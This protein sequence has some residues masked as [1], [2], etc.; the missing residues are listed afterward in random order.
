MKSNKI[1]EDRKLLSRR[2]V[3][4][5]LGVIA[6]LS[7]VAGLGPTARIA[8]AMQS[9]AIKPDENSVLLVIDFQNCFLPG[10]SL[11]VKGGSEITPVINALG[12]KFKN[13]VFTQDW[14]TPNHTSFA[15]SHPG[16]KPFETVKL[17]YG[18]QVLWPDHCVQGTKGA[19]LSPD[20]DIP[21]A[22]MIVRKGNHSEVDSYSAFLGADQ[23]TTTGL[24]GYLSERGLTKV[25]ICGLAIDFCIRWSAVHAR[26]IGLET[27][28]I[29]DAS[30]TIELN[31]SLESAWS[32][33]KASGVR[34]IQSTEIA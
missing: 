34:R 32:A 21:H 4:A 22:Q 30:G 17:S 33:M 11:A 9:G 14:H 8:S 23:M 7:A 3:L 25:F 2:T 18:D 19:E 12:R 26:S 28:V 16:K 10:G 13:V 15:S 29:E 6:G 24:A 1:L 31:G 20:L 5:G 27:F